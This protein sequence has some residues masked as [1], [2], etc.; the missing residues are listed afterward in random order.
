[1]V[2]GIVV[3]RRVAVPIA[4]C[5]LLGA[6]YSYQR[7]STTPSA[8]PQ[9][10]LGSKVRITTHD[11]RVITMS[12]SEIAADSVIGYL[13]PSNARFA[14]ALSDVRAIERWGMNRGRTGALGLGAVLLYVVVV[15][16]ALVLASGGLVG[17]Y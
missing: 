7:V 5:V 17:T 16:A 14:V 11:G 1:M 9:G 3:L 8:L 12:R 10:A 13:E 15:I 6:C 2:R 4:C